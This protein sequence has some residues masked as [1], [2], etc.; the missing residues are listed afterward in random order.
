MHVR[1]TPEE[2]DDALRA[3][4]TDWSG[5]VVERAPG[6]RWSTVRV[7]ERTGTSLGPVLSDLLSAPV[8]AVAV[9]GDRVSLSG[10]RGGRPTRADELAEEL[11]KDPIRLRDLLSDPSPAADR[12]AEAATL[13]GLPRPVV[14]G[15]EPVFDS[16][17]VITPSELPMA[18]ARLASRRR[19]RNVFGPLVLLEIVA[20][21]AVDYFWFL[22]PSVWLI[23][24]LAVFAANGIALLVLW[25]Y[26]R[27]RAVIAWSG[28]R[29]RR[30]R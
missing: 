7:A 16:R 18:K 29:S 3:V 12:H 20:F 17:A 8:V 1:A 11:G 23:P 25:R 10:W 2:L 19:A 22:E 30:S 4:A 5:Q 14:T 9:A 27:G 21:L 6:D 24:A 28:V 26:L 15:F 13:L